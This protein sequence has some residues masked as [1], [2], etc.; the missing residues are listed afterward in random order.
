MR[1]QKLLSL[2]KRE[3]TKYPMALDE[4]TNQHLAKKSNLRLTKTLD[5]TAYVQEIEKTE[6]R[7]ELPIM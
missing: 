1:S 3:T 5:P 6:E 4:R 7:G 2:Q